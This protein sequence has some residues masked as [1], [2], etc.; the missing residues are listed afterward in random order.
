MSRTPPLDTSPMAMPGWDAARRLAGSPSPGHTSPPGSRRI[1]S[2]SPGPGPRSGAYRGWMACRQLIGSMPLEDAVAPLACSG[3]R[4]GRAR[5]RA[6]APGGRPGP[7]QVAVGAAAPDERSQ[8]PAASAWASPPGLRRYRSAPG[9]GARRS[10]RFRHGAPGTDGFRRVV[11]I[12]T[13]SGRE[14]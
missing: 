12:S 6:Y 10:I 13:I 5:G 8:R 11:G 1:Q 4:N 14:S 2:R 7:L 9:C 3:A